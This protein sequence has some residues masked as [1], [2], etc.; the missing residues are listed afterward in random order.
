MKVCLWDSC[1][2][3]NCSRSYVKS[4]PDPHPAMRCEYV[5]EQLYKPCQR[6]ISTRIHR[7]CRWVLLGDHRS[8]LQV[9]VWNIALDLTWPIQSIRSLTKKVCDMIRPR[10]APFL[11]LESIFPRHGREE[12][13]FHPM[14]PFR[15]LILLRSPTEMRIR[16]PR[17]PVP[18]HHGTRTRMDSHEW[19]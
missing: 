12:L 9:Q 16:V 13:G 5:Y 6:K 2:W 18:A 19:Q 8:G 3:V 15:Q 14:H 4:D 17:E 1:R 7:L 11:R 10:L